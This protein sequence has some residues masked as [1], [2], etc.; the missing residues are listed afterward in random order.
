[1]QVLDRRAF[2]TGA[3]AATGLATAPAHAGTIGDLAAD[4]VIAARFRS[5]GIP[6]HSFSVPSTSMMPTIPKGNVVLADLRLAG[7]SPQRGDI[8]VFNRPDGVVYVKRVLALP[9]DSI[10]FANWIPIVNGSAAEWSSL[11]PITVETQTGPVTYPIVQERFPGLTP[12][13]I[14]MLPTDDSLAEL[15]NVPERY[16]ERDEVYVV[17]DNRRNSFDS[18]LSGWETTRLADMVGR[19]VYRFRPEPGWLVPK[20]TVAGYPF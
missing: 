5:V 8:V 2:L 14:A 17:G 4:M 20:T 3:A 7:R 13:R 1:M 10:A 6:I 18:R 15:A 16:V 11:D 19:V 12:Y 9:G